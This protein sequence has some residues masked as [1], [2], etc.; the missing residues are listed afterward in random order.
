MHDGFARRVLFVRRDDLGVLRG[1]DSGLMR[2]RVVHA[3]ILWAWVGLE[4]GQVKQYDTVGRAP[5]FIAT[6]EQMR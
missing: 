6:L 4:L 5:R 3:K 1:A 2:H